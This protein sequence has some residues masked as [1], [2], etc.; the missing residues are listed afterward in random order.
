MASKYVPNKWNMYDTALTFEENVKNG[1][2]ITREALNRLEQA[3]KE[4]NAEFVVGSVNVS[5]SAEDASASIE[6]NDLECTRRLN[7]TIPAGPKGD[8]GDK[9][10]TG[11]P[12]ADGAAATVSIGVVTTV[13]SDQSADV[14][15]TGT[16]TNAV[17]QFYIPKGEKG[18]PGVDGEQGPA[19]N[20]GEPGKAATI[21]VKE[22]VLVG[23]DGTAK[24]DV[25]GD[26]TDV[27]IQF[28]LPKGE[29]GD[30]GK[31][32]TIKVGDVTTVDDTQEANVVVAEGDDTDVTLNFTIPK[33]PK[34]EQGND[35]EDGEKGD[36]GAGFYYSIETPDESHQVEVSAVKPAGV[37]EGDYIMTST[38]AIYQV[39]AVEDKVTV[40]NAPVTTIVGPK[41]EQGIQGPDGQTGPQGE[42]G[43]A[44]TIEVGN[45][46]TC[47][48]AEDAKVEAV[49]GDTNV[50]LNFT[51]PK[52]EK[53]DRGET[54]ATGDKGETGPAGP[55]GNAGPAGER[56]PAGEKGDQ[57]PV[58]PAGADGK[59]ATIR[60]N[61]VT[62]GEPGTQANVVNSGSD[63][64]VS[65][66]IT[67]PRGDKGEPGVDGLP[68]ENGEK[69][70][71]GD[72]GAG[73]YVSA[74]DPSD[75]SYTLSL[76]QIKPEGIAM[77]DH[78][79]GADGNVYAVQSVSDSNITVV[80]SSACSLVGPQGPIG[81]DGKAGENG[82]NGEN[83]KDGAKGVGIYVSSEDAAEQTITLTSITPDGIAENDFVLCRDGKVYK[84]T[85]VDT[86]TVT[87]DESEVCNLKGP[88]GEAGATGAAG[89]PGAAGEAGAKGADAVINVSGETTH[90]QET[91]FKISADENGGSSITLTLNVPQGE[92]AITDADAEGEIDNLSD[93]NIKVLVKEMAKALKKI[94]LLNISITSV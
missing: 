89:A 32:A 48:S 79:L 10:E 40:A 53:G 39:L 25:T 9:G 86:D 90:V 18:D 63:T 31:A 44:A 29:K 91:G 1:A 33:G 85:T 16:D 21:T 81:P 62:T 28:T 65:L 11:D 6:Y 64:E 75:T 3:V 61:E 50:T 7:L 8:Q 14:T 58:G 22:E 59:A 55:Q 56:G 43:K 57:G 49:G 60:I 45:V 35:G 70:D 47:D 74:E 36:K 77:G 17:L 54:G 23:E 80:A 68:G 41:G 51:I 73:L 83:G 92:V 94:E 78:V 82:T 27:E 52:G 72:K 69:G 24:V 67:I 13:D 4:A 87:V 88:Q 37:A 12:G 84:V 66:N 71:K 2:V 26:G 15:N 38:G 34:G 42:P 30:P 46:V 93:E 76:D 19:G 20:D 5:D